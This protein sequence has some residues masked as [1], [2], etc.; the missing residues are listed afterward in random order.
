MKSFSPTDVQR[1]G[2]ELYNAVQAYGIAEIKHQSRPDMVVLTKDRL[3]DILHS[4]TMREAYIESEK[5][6]EDIGKIMLRIA[7]HIQE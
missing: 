7:S 1:K 4:E 5:A 6:G 2:V 3:Q